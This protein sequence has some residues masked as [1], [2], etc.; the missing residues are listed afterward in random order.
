[1]WSAYFGRSNV[2]YT[3]IFD[4]DMKRQPFNERLVEMIRGKR[5]N[6]FHV[7]YDDPRKIPETPI[8]VQYNF[9]QKP[10]T[11]FG[12]A[13]HNIRTKKWFVVEPAMTIEMKL[14]LQGYYNDNLIP[15]LIEQL[16]DSELQA[17]ISYKG[18]FPEFYKRLTGV[19]PGSR[20]MEELWKQGCSKITSMVE[21]MLM[22]R[23]QSGFVESQ[24][25]FPKGRPDDSEAY[26]L[27]AIREVE[28]ETGIKVLFENPDNS[29]RRLSR[30]NIS[31]SSSSTVFHSTVPIEPITINHSSSSSTSYAQ[32]AS[33]SEFVSNSLASTSPMEID[34]FPHSISQNIDNGALIYDTSR[35]LEQNPSSTLTV[36]QNYWEHCRV[37]L[38]TSNSVQGS[39]PSA[40]DAYLC[41]EYVSHAHSDMTGKMYKTTL[42]ICVF[43]AEDSKDI[44]MIGRTETRFGRWI[45]ED[46]LRTRFRVQELYLKCEATLNKYFPY[47]S[48]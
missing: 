11:S 14:L 25:I 13:F 5:E 46:V 39:G 7:L 10:K 47:L 38:P 36:K 6:I 20:L 18:D 40:R 30:H 26:F 15:F 2:D 33:S 4:Q 22:F 9:K 19:Y 32:V 29:I 3:S 21:K 28:E 23:D 24:Y 12:I 42:W 27:T 17:I 34:R 16:Y 31:S 37:V 44:Q 1:M 43:D 45:S 48:L 41:K 8:C 35:S